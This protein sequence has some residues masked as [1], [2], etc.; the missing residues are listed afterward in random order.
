MEVDGGKRFLESKKVH[1]LGDMKE[2]LI[3]TGII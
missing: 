2:G 1:K 3:Y